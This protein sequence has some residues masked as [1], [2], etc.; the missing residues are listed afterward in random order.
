MV[1]LTA[2]LISAIHDGADLATITSLI[3][4]HR[5]LDQLMGLDMC[6]RLTRLDLSDNRISSL[7][8]LCGDY[9]LYKVDMAVGRWES[10]DKFE[11]SRK[12]HETYDNEISSVCRLDR[13]VNLNT[14]VLSRNPIRNFGN[15]A[16]KL[17]SLKKV[18]G[19]ALKR[20][21][22]IEELRLAHNQLSSLPQELE[23]NGRLTILDLGT[24]YFKSWSDLQVLGTL[25]SLVNLNLRGNPICSQDG[26]EDEVRKRLPQL[27]VL[28][29]DTLLEGPRR[30]KSKSVQK[31]RDDNGAREQEMDS[32]KFV[33]ASPLESKKTSLKEKI[34]QK[35]SSDDS[36]TRS[37]LEMISL[38]TAQTE[39]KH[40]VEEPVGIKIGRDG[41]V[42]KKKED[43]GVVSVVDTTKG[44]HFLNKPKK[45][46]DLLSRLQ[47]NIEIGTGGPSTWDDESAPV[48]PGLVSSAPV[49]ATPPNP[50]SIPSASVLPD[51]P[52]VNVEQ[53]PYNRYSREPWSFIHGL[54]GTLTLHSLLNRDVYVERRQ[55]EDFLLTFSALRESDNVGRAQSQRDAD[56]QEMRLNDNRCVASSYNA[57]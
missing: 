23:R 3:V 37:F 13:L 4:P 21:A 42:K 57:V 33:E 24:N 15:F 44:R 31:S 32:D 20:C 55:R 50:R 11:R 40:A 2:A 48:T 8:V 25:H 36:K 18:I 35:G 16:S 10:V 7:E 49:F 9:F 52:V 43:S 30:K 47:P 53:K 26:Y 45:I 51:Q 39:E 54:V 28:D 6:E 1:R 17:M 5:D 41:K 29:G 46:D 14:V 22:T 12:L 34:G 19:S 27:Q 38:P 56:Q